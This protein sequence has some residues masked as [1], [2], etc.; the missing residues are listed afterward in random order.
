MTGG[1]HLRG[2]AKILILSKQGVK[3]QHRY[4]VSFVS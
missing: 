1:G 4:G 2:E 3:T